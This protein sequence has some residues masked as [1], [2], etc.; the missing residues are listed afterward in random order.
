MITED[1]VSEKTSELLK[2][3]GFNEECWC[4]YHLV[5]H[6]F[7]REVNFD[8]RHNNELPNYIASAPTLQMAIKWL[9]EVYNKHCDI[10]FDIEL[11]WYFQIID[12]KQIVKDFDYPE[13]KIYHGDND[14]GFQ[15]Y[16]DTA[17]AAIKYCLENLIIKKV[18]E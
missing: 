9:R 10:S 16:E 3:K 14:C 13:M 4:L 2:E 5:T 12:L 17:D 8:L 15:N 11:G 7:A 1:Y 18:E 6:K